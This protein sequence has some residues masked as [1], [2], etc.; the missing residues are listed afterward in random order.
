M[1]ENDS[2]EQPVVE[3]KPRKRLLGV[4]ITLV[5]IAGAGVI[6]TVLGPRLLGQHVE[7]EEPDPS[8]A[9]AEAEAA[10]VEADKPTNPMAFEPVI[11]DVRDKQSQ[12]H[13]M[14]IGLT[15][16]LAEGVKKEEFIRVMPRGR[17]AAIFYLRSKYYEDL[18]EPTQ[19]EIITKDLNTRIVKAMGEKLA[20]RVVITD[21]VAQ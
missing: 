18:T 5:L 7:T 16:E 21:F 9:S 3:K 12:A 8:A 13:H 4:L 2:K 1:A 19:F 14:K 17:E 10:E 20:K 15:I 11:I 6:G